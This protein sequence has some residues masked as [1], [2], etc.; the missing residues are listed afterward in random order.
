MN[1]VDIKMCVLFILKPVNAIL[2][3]AREFGVY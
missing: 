3:F 2:R 1:M